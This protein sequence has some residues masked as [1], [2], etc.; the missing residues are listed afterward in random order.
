[1]KNKLGRRSFVKFAAGSLLAIPVLANIKLA[2]ANDAEKLAEDDPMAMA[3]GY[4]EDTA[5]VDAASHPNHKPEQNCI[6]CVLYQ[7]DDPAWGG[8]GAFP[9]KKVA[10]NGWCVAYAAKPS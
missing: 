10:G 3:L 9:G 6:G 8:C 7:G 2:A 4:K 5:S 1:M